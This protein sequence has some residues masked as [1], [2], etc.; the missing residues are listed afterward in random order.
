MYANAV[1]F[2]PEIQRTGFSPLSLC[3]RRRVL[4]FEISKVVSKFWASLVT[5][6]S[7]NVF[8]SRKRWN[9]YRMEYFAANGPFHNSVLRIWSLPIC[10]NLSDF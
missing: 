1:S 4:S 5:T 6:L 10:S 2:A 9:Y 3:N 7:V 8:N